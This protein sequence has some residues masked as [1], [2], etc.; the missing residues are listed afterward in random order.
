MGVT[1]KAGK[2][3]KARVEA[4]FN[5]LNPFEQFVFKYLAHHLKMKVPK[6]HRE[7]YQAAYNCAIGKEYDRLLIEAPRSFAKSFIFSFF[8]PLYLMCEAGNAEMIAFSRDRG[9]AKK[10]LRYIKS[11]I[12]NNVLLHADYGIQPGETWSKEEIEYVR[13]DGF[14]G[15]FM[16]M[17]KGMSPRGW[18]PQLAII[19]DPQKTEDARSE[20]VRE[21]DWEW[22]TKDFA[23][24][25]QK[26]P[27]IFIGTRVHPLCMVAKTADIAGWHHLRFAALTPD[28][29][30]I[31][32]Q[33]MNE[34]DLERERKRIGDDAFLSEYMNQP[35]IS[36]NPVFRRDEFKLYSQDSVAF[37][38]MLRKGMYTVTFIDP[39]ISKRDVAD[40]TAIVTVSATLD[41]HPS[42]YINECKRGHWSMPEAVNEAF[43]TYERFHQRKTIVES[44]AYQLALYQQIEVEQNIRGRRINPYEIKQDRDKI[45]RAHSITRFF[46]E[47]RVFF[48]ESDPG[49]QRL[50]DELTLFPTGDHDDMVDSLVGCLQDVRDAGLGRIQ[51]TGPILVRA[52]RQKFGQ[53]TIVRSYEGQIVQR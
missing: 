15:T 40:Y 38:E 41:K 39:A 22:F 19:D 21:S 26:Q 20:T 48:D 31:W 6:F 42:V 33:H 2:Y 45:R 18:H 23:G 24:M 51:G 8:L 49:Q 13:S 10:F 7:L 14:V 34:A 36:E 9:L 12:Q 28:G 32:P 17:S 29:K 3:S 47:G 35:R 1:K 16:S 53:P 52:E 43:A 46:Q 37:Q 27:V 25:M 30:S 5:R 50:M 4:V 11:E 44:N